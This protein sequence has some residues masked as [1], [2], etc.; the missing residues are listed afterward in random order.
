[1]LKSIG[2]EK[3][4]KKWVML[5]DVFR[6]IVNKIDTLPIDLTGTHLSNTLLKVI[7]WKVVLWKVFIYLLCFP[8]LFM[9]TPR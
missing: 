5:I 1:M 8:F 4:L 9:L 7:L 2:L 3:I 6:A